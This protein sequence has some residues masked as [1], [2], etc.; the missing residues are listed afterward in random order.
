MR[1]YQ[2]VWQIWQLEVRHL[3][4]PLAL[5]AGAELLRLVVE[6]LGARYAVGMLYEPNPARGVIGAIDWAM[7]GA[8]WLITAIV[9]QREHLRDDRAFLW[10]RPMARVAVGAAKLAILLT[11]FA[12]I[13]GILA[14]ARLA[15][16]SAP[17]AAIVAAAAQL[18]VVAGARVLPAWWVALATRTLPQFFAIGVGV[19]FLLALATDAEMLVWSQPYYP[20]DYMRRMFHDAERR[21]DWQGVGV[22]GWLGALVTTACAAAAGLAPYLPRRRAIAFACALALG[23]VVRTR[24]AAVDE[25]TVPRAV[26]DAI[27]SSIRVAGNRVY[28]YTIRNEA[29]ADAAKPSPVW[30]GLDVPALPS[31]Y[32]AILRTQ[33]DAFDGAALTTRPGWTC[34]AGFGPEG[35]LPRNTAFLCGLARNQ[36]RAGYGQWFEAP[37]QELLDRLGA[38]VPIAGRVEASVVHHRAVAVLPIQAGAAFTGAEYRVELIDVRHLSRR[39]EVDLRVTSFPQSDVWSRFDLTIF[40]VERG[41]ARASLVCCTPMWLS[42]LRGEQLMRWPSIRDPWVTAYM[43]RAWPD[44]GSEWLRDAQLVVVETYPAG[45]MEADWASPDA[46]VADRLPQ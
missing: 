31:D 9:V 14:V 16:Y 24:P 8:T 36:R 17:P 39:M 5:V 18:V 43:L 38:R 3:R 27:R 13:P 7:L 37:R 12:A 6:E 33:A 45:R 21:L 29:G 4:V 22:H 28:A 35:V 15:A 26:A 1:A 34:C 11:L 20:D 10:T 23:L 40:A 2:A 30:A 19:L 32:E 42:A 44:G 41:K 25:R 46:Y